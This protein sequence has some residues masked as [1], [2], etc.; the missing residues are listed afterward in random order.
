MHNF[1]CS[2][3]QKLV[4][5]GA[6][7]L[8]EIVPKEEKTVISY[9]EETKTFNVFLT[10]VITGPEDYTNVFDVLSQATEDETIKFYLSGPGGRL[11]T[12]NVLRG[13]LQRTS[14]GSLIGIIGDCASAHTILALSFDDIEVMDNIE[15]M[16]HNYSGGTAGKG[17][18][19]YTHADFLKENMPKVFN[20]FYKGFL[21]EEECKE[22]VE[23][24]DKYLNS[25]EVR[26]R[27]ENVKEFREKEIEEATKLMEDEIVKAQTEFAV[28]H[29]TDLGYNISDAVKPEEEEEEDVIKEM[30][31]NTERYK[32][33][34][35]TPND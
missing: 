4:T 26:E 30:I 2:N 10:Q 23:G 27:W 14:A 15:F 32:Q 7:T 31:E 16:I 19:I 9:N 1:M 35:P 34:N 29:L 17:H 8:E 33:E 13:C 21:T 20:D 22:V 25:S 18:E 6:I 3:V 5:A 12:V 11:D 28:K 24:K